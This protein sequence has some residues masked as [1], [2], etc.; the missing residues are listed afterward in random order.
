[1]RLPSLNALRA[2]EAAARHES[3][4][5]AAHELCVTEGAI[6]RHIKVL[7]EELGVVLFHRMTRKVELTQQ[8]QR[9]LPVLGKAFAAIAYGVAQVS[10][11]KH[12]LKVISAH[13]LSLRWLVPRLEKFRALDPGFGVDLTTKFYS[14]DEFVNRDF[15]V[16]FTCTLVAVPKGICAERFIEV[17]LTPACA[18]RLLAEKPLA[19]VADLAS[20]NLL[21]SSEDYYDW[22]RWAHKFG[23]ADFSVARGQAY[24]NRY[25]AAQAAVIGEGIAIADLSLMKNEFES[26]R[27]TAPFPT[28][29]YGSPEDDYSFI[30]RDALRSDPRVQIFC[31]WRLKERDAE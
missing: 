2:F 19:T 30:C 18:P 22:N 4:A 27:L 5:K 12:D 25:M 9:L 10:A 11:G 15:E 14:W 23:G 3:F 24:P 28:M 21:H 31:D 20:F 29:I 1:M 16:G 26:G 13:T 8:G 6:S 17:A 7:E